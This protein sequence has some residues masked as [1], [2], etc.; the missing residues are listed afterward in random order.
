MSPL[1][2][3]RKSEKMIYLP[4]TNPMFIDIPTMNFIT[5]SGKGNPNDDNFKHYIEALY[6]VSYAIRMSYKKE[7]AF[8][9]RVYPLE[10]VWDILDSAKEEESYSLNKDDFVFKLMIRQP[11]RISKAFIEKKIIETS[12]KKPQ[13]LISNIQFE[14][15]F[16]GPCLQMMHLGSY[17]D[18]A[19]S[20]EQMALFEKENHLERTSKKHREIYLTD[21]RKTG[22][23]KQKTILRY[24]VTVR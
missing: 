13:P 19:K 17:D 1:Y 18:E 22:P 16:E 23:E 10:G 12:K 7:T 3:W 15:I 11:D 21:A 14:T 9:Y 20:F 4:K 6:N 5:L 24:Q 8:E 2:E